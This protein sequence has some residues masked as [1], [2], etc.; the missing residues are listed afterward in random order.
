[1]AVETVLKRTWPAYLLLLVVEAAC[2][3]PSPREA[4]PGEP[5]EPRAARPANEAPKPSPTPNLEHAPLPRVMPSAKLETAPPPKREA[6]PPQPKI[7]DERPRAPQVSLLRS[8]R[9]VPEVQDGAVVGLRLFGIRPGSLLDSIGLRSGDRL[10]SINGFSLASPE[11]ALEAYARLQRAERLN[12][13]LQRKGAPVELT[14]N[15]R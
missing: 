7:V 15:V 10:E 14:L 13:R 2:L 1:M 4:T 8:V 11:K 5:L 3:W 6:P 12:V 9:V